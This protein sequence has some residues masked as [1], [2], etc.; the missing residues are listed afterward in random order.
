LHTS[1]TGFS[2]DVLT[3]GVVAAG[4]VLTVTIADFV[5]PFTDWNLNLLGVEAASNWVNMTAILPEVP[6]LVGS[7]PDGTAS[8]DHFSALSTVVLQFSEDV[9]AGEGTVMLTAVGDTPSLDFNVT[10]PSITFTGMFLIVETDGMMPGE[11]YG[12]HI[13]N[14]TVRGV[15]GRSGIM[16]GAYTPKRFA[17]VPEILFQAAGV[18]KAT[19][20]AGVTFGPDNELLVIG[21]TSDPDKSATNRTY[22]STTY[23]DTDALAGNAKASQCTRPCDNK[24]KSTVE[25]KIFRAPS[26]RG[27][28]QGN[29]NGVYV[30]T[31]VDTYLSTEDL[32]EQCKCPNCL[33]VP[34][35]L[36]EVPGNQKS[37]NR[38]YGP[39]DEPVPAHGTFPFDQD[40]Y[41]QVSAADSEVKL[42]CNVGPLM[43]S[44]LKLEQGYEP[45]EHFRCT[46]ASMSDPSDSA[47]A[48]YF[49]VWR[50]DEGACAEKPCLEYPSVLGGLGDAALPQG[51]DS[52]DCRTML[53]LDGNF[54]MDS[55]RN[56]SVH[57]KA[58]YKASTDADDDAREFV[59]DRG[60]YS[61]SAWC[62]RRVCVYADEAKGA[63]GV[64]AVDSATVDFEG[65]ITVQCSDGWQP[66]VEEASCVAVNQDKESEVA[67]VPSRLTCE[68]KKCA[69]VSIE[70]GTADCAGK[71]FGDTCEVSC[72]AGKMPAAGAGLTT[73]TCNEPG[74]GGEAQWSAFSCVAITCNL[75]AAE[76]N[77][78]VGLELAPSGTC[79]SNGA[80]DLNVPCIVPC[81]E[82]YNGYLSV[83]CEDGGNAGVITF[84]HECSMVTCSATGATCGATAGDPADFD[85]VC[86]WDCGSGKVVA[87]VPTTTSTA[88]VKCGAQGSFLVCS[89]QSDDSCLSAESAV[90]CAEQ[91][92]QVT[93]V[94]KTR[95]TADLRVCACD[96]DSL[97][98][99]MASFAA[100]MVKTV[101]EELG[102]A[103]EEDWTC[104]VECDASS[105][106]CNSLR[107]RRLSEETVSFQVEFLLD[108]PAADK[109]ALTTTLTTLNSNPSLQN[110]L[111]ESIEAEL[112]TQGVEV[113][114]KGMVVSA[115]ETVTVFEEQKP[116]PSP[117]SAE[118]G[119]SMM[120]IIGGLAVVA[121]IIIV[122][123]VYSKKGGS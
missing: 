41:V 15:T 16:K 105:N 66:L 17:T 87:G 70:G 6:T 19:Q 112:A 12:V 72:D 103:Q 51:Y 11:E 95:V 23:R 81:T 30:S 69:A 59:C 114:I 92:S 113:A 115:P 73:M 20:D 76:Y 98:E 14:G 71:F 118:E 88:S 50:I 22:R 93:E 5:S 26:V 34:P 9:Q 31:T 58:G 62:K 52:T 106:N 90:V 80:Q 97:C 56:C 67:F 7:K 32:V 79:A 86:T 21:G 49:G 10:S 107:A 36:S 3:A 109:E 111:Q 28:R 45:V 68:K 33:K 43:D 2:E 121:V 27:L 47:V 44:S 122:G 42:T 104:G 65:K 24:A 101:C 13:T 96:V 18:T 84:E 1:E 91:G 64:A 78:F 48:E 123:V 4:D 61:A 29:M 110:S 94:K 116:A 74:V 63:V 60:I 89:D 102:N 54:T 120:M 108:I 75:D 53:A 25:R 57:C 77:N 119:G 35:A 8:S 83:T 85:E 99:N 37:S 55:G 82:G 39:A 40:T 100:A 117:D 38:L 46:I